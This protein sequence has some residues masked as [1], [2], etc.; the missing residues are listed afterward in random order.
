[1]GLYNEYFLYLDWTVY[2]EGGTAEGCVASAKAIPSFQ[3]ARKVAGA[4]EI[5][6]SKCESGIFE[7]QYSRAGGE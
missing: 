5:Q 1:M 6:Q 3:A 7:G 2:R 4:L